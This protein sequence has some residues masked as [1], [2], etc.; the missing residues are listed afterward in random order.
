[1]WSLTSIDTFNAHIYQLEIDD[2]YKF[3]TFFSNLSENGFGFKVTVLNKLDLI[4]ARSSINKTH[5]RKLLFNQL[6]SIF[7]LDI[8]TNLLVSSS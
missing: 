8:V 2:F 6:F 4:S 3:N 7:R 5:L 1:M